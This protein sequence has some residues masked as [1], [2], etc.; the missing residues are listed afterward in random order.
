[1]V[2]LTDP[3]LHQVNEHFEQMVDAMERYRA[4]LL[5]R[6]ARYEAEGR[7]LRTYANPIANNLKRIDR[8][9]EALDGEVFDLLR[10]L[11]DGSGVLGSVDEGRWI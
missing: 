10:N 3:D 7:E 9:Q 4:T 6:R 2:A 5:S 1:M 8:L 11:L